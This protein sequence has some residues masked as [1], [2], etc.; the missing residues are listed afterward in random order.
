MAVVV[1]I[2]KKYSKKILLQMNF[3]LKGYKHVSQET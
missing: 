3:V 1:T 2:S